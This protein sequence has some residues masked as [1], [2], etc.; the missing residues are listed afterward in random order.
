MCSLVTEELLGELNE[1]GYYYTTGYPYDIAIQINGKFP[2]TVWSRDSQTVPPPPHPRGCRWS[3]EGG[4][5][6]N[7]TRDIF[8]LNEI[9]VEGK[10]YIVETFYLSLTVSIG[11]Q[12]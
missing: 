10:I 12:S 3:S 11:T 6:V 5:Q 9:R 2:L 1:G 7:C 8:I 4:P